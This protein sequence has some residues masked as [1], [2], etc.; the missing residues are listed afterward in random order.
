MGNAL[1]KAFL[2][3]VYLHPSSLTTDIGFQKEEVS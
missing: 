1:R 2:D 3:H